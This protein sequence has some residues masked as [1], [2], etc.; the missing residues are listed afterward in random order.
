MNLK[1]YRERVCVRPGTHVWACTSVCACVCVCVCVRVCVCVCIN[2]YK[3]ASK[4]EE[5]GKRQREKM[6]RINKDK[7]IHSIW[8]FISYD[9]SLFF[10]LFLVSSAMKSNAIT[11]KMYLYIYSWKT[12]RERER[13]RERGKERGDY[14]FSQQVRLVWWMLRQLPIS[15]RSQWW[16]LKFSFPD[17]WYI[18]KTEFVQENE[19]YKIR[20]D[21]EIQIDH[22]IPT[23]RPINN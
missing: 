19:T 12:E 10:I 22:Q 23:W 6:W 2:R 15:H 5:E 3:Y 18:H 8:C 9:S 17:K 1:A 21:F 20:W 14:F 7:S 4:W 13:E 16:V 11:E